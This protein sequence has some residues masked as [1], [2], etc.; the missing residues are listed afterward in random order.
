MK[1]FYEGSKKMLLED[2]REIRLFYYLNE[3]RNSE[4]TF[5][6]ITVE[7]QEGD[8]TETVQTGGLI[9]SCDM[10]MEIVQKLMEN[11]VTPIAALEIIDDMMTEQALF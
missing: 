1:V 9:E 8:L 4:H 6:D 5:Y 10:A 11:S 7:K 3:N 2:E